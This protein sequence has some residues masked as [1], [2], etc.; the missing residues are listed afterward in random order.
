MGSIWD[1]FL[2]QEED[3]RP[4]KISLER[5][6]TVVRKVY[7]DLQ[8]LLGTFIGG[9]LVAGYLLAANFKTLDEGKKVRKTWIYAILLTVIIFCI[10]F[11][12]PDPDKVPRLLI[13]F[14]Y[15]GIV[16]FLIKKLQ[17]GNVAHYVQEGG[18]VYS[19]WRTLGIAL[20]GVLATLLVFVGVAH[21]ADPSAYYT[22]KTYGVQQHE[23]NF[24]RNN[25]PEKEVDQIANAL[26]QATFFD[27]ELKKSVFVQKDQG[28]Y[29]ISIVVVNGV[30][31]DPNIVTPFSQLRDNVQLFF[32]FNKVIINLVEENTNKV[33]R[34]IE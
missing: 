24:Y 9:P 26:T 31:S 11:L 15:T 21:Y 16:Y 25:I 34:R 32:P 6:K 2:A 29:E 14:I 19:W 18:A 12:V 3:I 7:Q 4:M 30:G 1:Y 33:E 13:P 27:D 17:K 8:I 10:I 20:I 5:R 22:T 23:I 28:N